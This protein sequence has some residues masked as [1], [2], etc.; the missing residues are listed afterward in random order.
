MNNMMK[1]RRWMIVV[2]VTMILALD[3]SGCVSLRRKFVRKRDTKNAKEAFIP[4]LDPVEY[5]PVVHA[6]IKTYTTHYA[7][8]RAYYKDVW[9][10]L[11]KDENVKRERYLLVQVSSKLQAMALLLT[12][13]SS[14]KLKALADKVTSISI[15][16]DK[17][18]ALRRYDLMKSDLKAVERELYHSFK[19]VLIEPF[20]VVS[21]K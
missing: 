13:E 18:Q 12:G 8:V 16:L 14:G 15:E 6:P 2:L 1:Y 19:P 3:M 4:V 17:P 21:K 9:G 11:G 7:V 20:L 10:T 5:Q